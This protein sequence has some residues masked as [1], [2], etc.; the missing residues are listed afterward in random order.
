[1]KRTE[2]LVFS[3]CLWRHSVNGTMFQ[4][5]SNSI[6]Q[7]WTVRGNEV[8]L[9]P[10]S[11][12]SLLKQSHAEAKRHVACCLNN[13]IRAFVSTLSLLC[14]TYCAVHL[15]CRK[16]YTYYATACGTEA[17]PVR[18]FLRMT[19]QEMNAK[20]FLVCGQVMKVWRT[21]TFRTVRWAS[22]STL[23]TPWPTDCMTC[24][25]TSAPATWG[26]VTP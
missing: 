24:T 11:E 20:R 10:F 16:K 17:P 3:F 22:L 5:D 21:T 7:K 2:L 19:Y 26:S 18:L 25:L 6:L 9:K 14:N 13:A 23:S 12:A 4:A 15:N 1:M 8:S